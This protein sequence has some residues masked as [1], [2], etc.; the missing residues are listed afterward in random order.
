M[1]KSATST[2]FTMANPSQEQP[3]V[4]TDLTN[5]VRT[6]LTSQMLYEDWKIMEDMAFKMGEAQF[7]TAVLTIVTSGLK[8]HDTVKYRLHDLRS[9]LLSK[10]F[11]L[12]GFKNTAVT[13]HSID[14]VSMDIFAIAY[15]LREGTDVQPADF[16][17]LKTKSGDQPTLDRSD[18]A[19]LRRLVEEFTFLKNTCLVLERENKKLKSEISNRPRNESIFNKMGQSA[20]TKRAERSDDDSSPPAPKKMDN[21]PSV[22]MNLEA[23]RSTL[24]YSALASKCIDN[25]AMGST[26]SS[27]KG[28]SNQSAQKSALQTINKHNG[29]N[30]SGLN[31]RP[32]RKHVGRS[33]PKTLVIGKA[34]D[35]SLKSAPKKHHFKVGNFPVSTTVDQV[36]THIETFL[37]KGSFEVKQIQLSHDNYYRLFHITIDATLRDRLLDDSKWDENIRIQRYFMPRQP[38]SNSDERPLLSNVPKKDNNE[39]SC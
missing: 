32:K 13:R 28:K 37:D 26:P 27:R 12:Q 10:L 19:I 38:R 35:I 23:S 7:R 11:I 22:S 33:G 25:G 39:T 8:N 30:S 9:I 34:S 31:D 21:C 5:M 2:P 4:S 3:N 36:K 29:N 16:E 17:C 14:K 18:E 20:K 24:S 6:F 15:T 1:L